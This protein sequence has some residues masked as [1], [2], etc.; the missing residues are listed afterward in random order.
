MKQ[1]RIGKAADNDF[2]VDN[3]HVSRHHAR[4]IDEGGGVL[5][6]E[7]LNSAN[8]VYIN[9]ACVQR[10]RVKASDEILLADTYRLNLVEVLKLNND[11]A[12]E[13]EK[14]K[15][16]YDRYVREKIRIQ[17]SN[18]LKVRLF[19]TVPYA[20]PGV[21]GVAMGFLGKGSTLLFAMSLVLVLVVPLIGIYFGAKQSSKIPQQLSDI[22]T[23]F[24][25]DYVCPK[26][27]TFLGEV[28]WESLQKRKQCPISS[29]K[30]HWIHGS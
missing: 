5:F 13:F 12:E 23:Q 14:L 25:I 15:P 19:Q 9:G 21:I 30:A 20:L 7:D 27:G 26:C 28:P 6:I 2:V 4:L 16:I 3:P 11:Y 29:C 24:K 8:G 22:S 18:Q 17:S 10:K 1:I